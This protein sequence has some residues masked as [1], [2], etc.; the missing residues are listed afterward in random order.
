[1][2]F[3]VLGIF[4]FNVQ[5]QQGAVLQMVNHGI[6][7]PALFL[8][9]AWI[10]DR[11][12][13]RDRSAL[14]GLASRMPVM[15]GVFIVVVLAALGLPGLNSFVGEFMTLLGAW[16]RAPVLAVMGAV[17]LVLAP[18]YMLRLFQGTMHGEPADH[19]PMSDIRTGQLVLVTPL[20][21]LMFVLGLY[22]NLLTQLMSALGQVGLA[23]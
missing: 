11:A 12:G 15:A 13:T 17:G 10:A 8:L 4:A 19:Q 16:E 18:V 1:M 5:G 7:V 23:R 3:I 20:I 6:I 21:L 14:A 2:G 9:V 22:P